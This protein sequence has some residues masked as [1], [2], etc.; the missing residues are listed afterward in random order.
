MQTDPSMRD[1][2]LDGAEKH[3]QGQV[4]LAIHRKCP[5]IVKSQNFVGWD[6]ILKGRMSDEWQISC[7]KHKCN[8][9]ATNKI[10]GLMWTTN[11]IHETWQWFLKEWMDRNE[12]MHGIN[13]IA[14]AQKQQKQ[15]KN[16]E[17]HA[18]TTANGKKS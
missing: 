15:E 14:K 4:E 2:L 17:T 5:K 6:Q 12:K 9:N 18:Q 8:T 1:L 11:I 3:F 13:A 16:S 7:N 10:D